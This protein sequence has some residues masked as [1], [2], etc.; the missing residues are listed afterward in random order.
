MK[1]E[2]LYD[3]RT[4]GLMLQE[5]IAREHLNDM[6]ELGKVPE[7]TK[8]SS[9]IQVKT[10]YLKFKIKLPMIKADDEVIN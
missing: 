10:E 5:F 7:G 1:E 6:I 2:D 4:I 8:L 3:K 9:D